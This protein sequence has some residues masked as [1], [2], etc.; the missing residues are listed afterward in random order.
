MM[1]GP[2]RMLNNEAEVLDAARGY[3][4]E[5]HKARPQAAADPAT[6]AARPVA[7]RGDPANSDKQLQGLWR[8]C[9]M[10]PASGGPQL[11]QPMT[12]EKLAAA[13]WDGYWAASAEANMAALA[14]EAP[15]REAAKQAA[16]RVRDQRRIAKA[17]A[18]MV[19][20][21]AA[22]AWEYEQRAKAVEP[23]PPNP[24]RGADRGGPLVLE[25]R[26]ERGNWWRIGRFSQEMSHLI[27][28]VKR[29]QQRRLLD[30]N[31][32]W[33]TSQQRFEADG[34]YWCPK[35]PV[36][37]AFILRKVVA[38]LAEQDAAAAIKATKP[39][40]AEPVL[41]APAAPGAP[42]FAIPAP[43]K[44]AAPLQLALAF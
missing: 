44:A 37:P 19:A 34:A 9:Q 29:N 30:Q 7:R 17:G 15:Q 2:W 20:D 32:I 12:F 24:M 35:P 31:A 11:E 42:G 40:P 33:I 1:T 6:W 27:R 13:W 26:D 41:V 4:R 14:A 16:E 10:G 38:I 22:E 23:E 8:Y 28:F 18:A 25:L 36:V 39:E 3:G 21:C 5:A 43:P